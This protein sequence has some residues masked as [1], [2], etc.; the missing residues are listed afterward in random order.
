MLFRSLGS[1]S[2]SS[3]GECSRLFAISTRRLS[4]PESVSAMSRASAREDTESSSPKHSAVAA[5]SGRDAEKSS[6]SA[7]TKS[8]KTQSTGSAESS[9][10]SS[11]SKKLA[12]AS[13]SNTPVAG[14][15]VAP[16]LGRAYIV[17]RGDCLW[18]ITKAALA[19]R[20]SI[21]RINN[22][23]QRVWRANAS[24]IGGNPHLIFPGQ[25]LRIP[26]EM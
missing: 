10:K 13:T 8:A 5:R 11:S 18:L 26:K 24:T 19:K 21:V 6:G 9:R 17:R 15:R 20:V 22:G 12:S 23:W 3:R 25:V 14:S 1:S 16:S 4:P 2:S 7:T